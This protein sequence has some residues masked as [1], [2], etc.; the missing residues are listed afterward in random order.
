MS[1]FWQFCDFEEVAKVHRSQR[2]LRRG[3]LY[4]YIAQI[5]RNVCSFKLLFQICDGMRSSLK[6]YLRTIFYPN[7]KKFGEG[8]TSNFADLPPNRCQSE[9]RNLETAEYIDK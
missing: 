1:L 2:S 9:A 3:P 5:F 8:K 7:P 6:T 4:M